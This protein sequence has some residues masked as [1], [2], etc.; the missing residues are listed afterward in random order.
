MLILLQFKKLQKGRKNIEIRKF[1]TF[2]FEMKS[3]TM[4]TGVVTLTGVAYLHEEPTQLL[5]I[6]NLMIHH[7]RLNYCVYYFIVFNQ[8]NIKIF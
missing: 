6:R 8:I 3:T 2:I 1:Y 5:C 4:V 7:S